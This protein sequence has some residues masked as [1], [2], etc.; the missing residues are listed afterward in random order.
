MDIESHA[1]WYQFLLTAQ[2]GH[3]NWW[4]NLTGDVDWDDTV[5]GHLNDG[6]WTAPQAKWAWQYTDGYRVTM[7]T[8]V[9]GA[10]GAEHDCLAKASTDV[11]EGNPG[12]V[13]M[14]WRLDATSPNNGIPVDFTAVRGN[15][16]LNGYNNAAFQPG[17]DAWT[18]HGSGTNDFPFWTA[19]GSDIWNSATN[20]W[21][22][23][24]QGRNVSTP[25]TGSDIW[26]S[27][28]QP[29]WQ[30]NDYTLNNMRVSRGDILTLYHHIL[31]NTAV[32]SWVWTM[33]ATVE[34]LE[35]AVALGSAAAFAF[36]VAAL[37][38]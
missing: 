33:S 36:G 14:C 34:V 4:I 8:T 22:P 18:A 25:Q 10:V 19:A 29:K 7:K 38:F 26:I 31:T 6:T 27:W 32:N 13:S 17:Y 21:R 1:T 11:G 12:P 15:R 2:N 24:I 28:F 23:L 5:F 35:G 3:G 20:P 30:R 16:P 37:S 9:T